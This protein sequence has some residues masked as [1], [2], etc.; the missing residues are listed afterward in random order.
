MLPG[1]PGGVSDIPG[2]TFFWYQQAQDIFGQ[3]LFDQK[4]GSI[5]GIFNFFCICKGY[6]GFHI[7]AIV[8]HDGCQAIQVCHQQ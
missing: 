3:V 6:N 7:G 2:C 5:G 8:L 1:Q 4:T